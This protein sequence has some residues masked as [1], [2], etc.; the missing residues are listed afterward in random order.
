VQDVYQ[1]NGGPSVTTW[2]P[3]IN[4]TTSGNLIVLIISGFSNGSGDLLTSVN[5]VGASNGLT[6]TEATGTFVNS[7]GASVLFSDIFYCMN[8]PS[9][10]N[11]TLHFGFTYPGSN[12]VQAVQATIAEFSGA[13]T[14][15][16][17]AGLGTTYNNAATTLVSLATT[18]SVPQTNDLVV[19]GTWSGVS[20]PT[21][22]GS[23]QID[24]ASDASKISSYQLLTSG[25][26]T[27]TYTL[28]SQTAV[29]SIAAFKHP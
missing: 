18:G 29:G 9:S 8:N 10:A 19:S 21:A 1:L 15:S 24:F 16:A 20:A 17:D 13:A 25:V 22:I 3:V 14:T 27:H 7:A 6:C 11:I 4:G 28:A 5:F 2:L 12:S 26:I 23:G